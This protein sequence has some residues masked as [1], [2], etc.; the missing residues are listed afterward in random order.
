MELGLDVV[1]REDVRRLHDVAVERVRARLD[2]RA[3]RGDAHPERFDRRV[4]ARRARAPGASCRWQRWRGRP[5]LAGGR[6]RV[7]PA[8]E[9][10]AGAAE[11]IEAVVLRRRRRCPLDVDVHHDRLDVDLAP[12]LIEPRDDVAHGGEVVL[13]RGHEDRV[14]RL[15]GAHLHLRLEHRERLGPRPRLRPRA[16]R[17]PLERFVDRR[18]DLLR[19]GVLERDDVD[20]P[21]VRDGQ[22]DP[23][24]EREHALVRRFAADDDER[25][26]AVERDEPREAIHRRGAGAPPSSRPPA[27]GR[28]PRPAPSA[29]AAALT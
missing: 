5:G 3:E 19:V 20:G 21:L 26:R 27:S 18:D 7:H 14:R 12:R 6:E 13:R 29:R 25:V 24:E 8:V 16:S 9:R 11:R 4:R 23:L 10:R 15:L 2:E 22:I 17:R 1:G 28:T